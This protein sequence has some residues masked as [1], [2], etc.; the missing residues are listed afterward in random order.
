MEDRRS[1]ESSI[2]RYVKTAFACMIAVGLVL[3]ASRHTFADAIPPAPGTVETY[4][5]QNGK[6]AVEIK[7]LGYPDSSPCECTFKESGDISWTKEIP[8]TPNKVVISD[9]GET[10]AMTNWGWY[11]EGGSRSLSIYNKRGDLIKELSFGFTGMNNWGL[12]WVKVLAISP[13]GSYCMV[14]EDAEE[15]A[16]FSLYDCRTGELKWE[17]GYG[18]SEASEAEIQEAG[19]YLLVATNDYSTRD[20]FFFLLDREGVTL[21]EKRIAKNFSWDVQ[22]YLRFMDNGKEFAIFDLKSAKYITEPV[23][24]EQKARL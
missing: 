17:R 13:D 9:N 8:D 19:R 23:P 20:M 16:V 12:K 3:T 14:G 11:D 18:F 10:I 5:S 24:Q 21:W 6:Y 1:G 2:Q 22:D 15:K 7:I 4:T